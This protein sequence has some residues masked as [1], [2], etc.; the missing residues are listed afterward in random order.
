M[1][2]CAASYAGFF[3]TT[4]QRISECGML[5]NARRAR[6]RSSCERYTKLLGIVDMGLHTTSNLINI[7]IEIL[8]PTGQAHHSCA[9]TL[10]PI[11]IVFLLFGLNDALID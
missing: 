2:S 6:S 7:S 11:Y 4:I 9:Q 5:F 1:R 8:H 10:E 3:I